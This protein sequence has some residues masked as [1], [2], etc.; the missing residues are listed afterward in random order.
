[1][2]RE[3]KENFILILETIATTFFVNLATLLAERKINEYTLTKQ[4][5]LGKSIFSTMRAQQTLPS[6]E[7]LIKLA[8]YFNVSVDF[9]LGIGQNNVE[10]ELNNFLYIMRWHK[11]DGK[12]MGV[13]NKPIKWIERKSLPS[14]QE[15][16]KIADCLRLPQ[17]YFGSQLCTYNVTAM[18]S[19]TNLAAKKSVDIEKKFGISN[20]RVCHHQQELTHETLTEIA[21]NLNTT[22]NFILGRMESIP[23]PALSTQSPPDLQHINDLW[24]KLN[25]TDKTAI[26]TY[27]DFIEN[28][29]QPENQTT[30]GQ[31]PKNGQVG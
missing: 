17:G 19:I 29:Q 20:Y 31:K 21:K 18:R 27:I 26:N 22:V 13:G 25:D 10:H 24:P 28:K 15:I 2:S 30:K 5:G 12:R 9:M 14:Q 7:T 1:M 3:I 23:K 6:A 4:I 8:E 11:E 16:A